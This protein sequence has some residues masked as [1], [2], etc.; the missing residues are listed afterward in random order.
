MGT[1]KGAGKSMRMR[2]PKVPFSKLSLSFFPNHAG[3]NTGRGRQSREAS[4]ACIWGSLHTAASEEAVCKAMS[5][6]VAGLQSLWPR[7]AAS[8]LSLVGSSDEKESGFDKAMPGRN[9]G[10]NSI[11]PPFPS[12]LTIR[13]LCG[14]GARVYVLKPFAGRIPYAPLSFLHP[15]PLEGLWKGISRVGGGWGVKNL[16]PC[17]KLH[18][19]DKD[20]WT[21]ARSKVSEFQESDIDP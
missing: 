9:P 4:I 16:G 18:R 12:F 21:N 14:R 15:S 19:L 10:R 17:Q 8:I 6:I 13:H 2:L 7:S 3:S 20:I 11:P 1:G 5:I